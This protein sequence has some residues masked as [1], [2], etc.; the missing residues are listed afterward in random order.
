MEVFEDG[1]LKLF[2]TRDL[3]DKLCF[4]PSHFRQRFTT[5]FEINN[6]KLN[7]TVLLVIDRMKVSL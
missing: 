4:A 3:I 1:L 5:H 7:I 2:F 6:S